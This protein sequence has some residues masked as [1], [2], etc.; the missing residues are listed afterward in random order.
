[1]ARHAVAALL[2]GGRGERGVEFRPVD[3]R[4]SGV[5]RPAEARSRRPQAFGRDAPQ[6]PQAAAWWLAQ[7]AVGPGRARTVHVQPGRGARRRG[8]AEPGVGAAAHG[9]SLRSCRCGGREGD[10]RRRS[11][12]RDSGA[13]ACRGDGARA[14][15]AGSG[16]RA[17][18]RTGPL[19]RS[20]SGTRSRHV[21]RVRGR[22]RAACV[23]QASMV[24]TLEEKF[25]GEVAAAPA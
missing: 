11:R 4:R 25:G 10:R 19:R 22:G 20:C 24:Q 7:C 15:A 14:P 3:A 23:C 12:G 8:Q 6:P 18:D 1:M 17:R 2:A 13:R 9:G 5:E 21:G 16:A